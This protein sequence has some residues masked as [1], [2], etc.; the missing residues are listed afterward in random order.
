MRKHSP[1]RRRPLT[2]AQ[3]LPLPIEQVRRLSLKHH[4]A[5]AA[6]CGGCGD[7]ESIATLSNMLALAFYLR[8]DGE[9]ELYRCADTALAQCIAR[10]ER[11]DPWTLTDA[12]RAALEALLLV[13]DGQLAAVSVHRYLEALEQTQHVDTTAFGLPNKSD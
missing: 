12:E 5:L 1:L 4:L 11:G 10:A 9:A 8:A 3:L 2:K 13:H 7:V 6:L